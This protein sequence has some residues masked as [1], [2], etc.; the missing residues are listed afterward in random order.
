MTEKELHKIFSA[1]LRA[2][3][4]AVHWTQAQVAK[5]AGITVN[6]VNDLEAGKKWASPATML[7]IAAVFKME[8]YELFKPPHAFPDNLGSI[9]KK[10]ADEIHAAVDGTRHSLLK[11]AEAVMK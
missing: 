5:K 4:T 2:R 10:Y 1:N 9:L 11:E 6:F 3:R 8:A 7:R